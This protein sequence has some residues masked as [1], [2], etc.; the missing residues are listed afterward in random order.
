VAFPQRNAN[1]KPGIG[2]GK[3]NNG[4]GIG[5]GGSRRFAPEIDPAGALTAIA[6]LSGGTLMIRGRR[7]QA[8]R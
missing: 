7:K 4:N 5:N 8:D 2:N 3:G 1:A 6:L